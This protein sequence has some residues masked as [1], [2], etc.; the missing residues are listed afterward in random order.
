MYPKSKFNKAYLLHKG[1]DNS[2]IYKYIESVNDISNLQLLPAIRNVE[3]QDMDYDLWFKEEYRTEHEM[4]QYKIIHYIPD[5][6][7]SYENFLEFN[8]KRKQLLR[9]DL[10]KL[11]TN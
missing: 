3:K 2:M 10:I 7:C 6:D 4:I 5:V 1:I 11:L 9:S 8:E